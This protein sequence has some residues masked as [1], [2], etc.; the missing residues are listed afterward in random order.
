[1]ELL[2]GALCLCQQAQA[3]KAVGKGRMPVMQLSH[4]YE[5]LFRRI[6]LG[7]PVQVAVEIMSSV[8]RSSLHVI[9]THNVIHSQVKIFYFT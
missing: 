5:I 3:I 9:A 7:S 1:M 2:V 6:W 8:D 4:T